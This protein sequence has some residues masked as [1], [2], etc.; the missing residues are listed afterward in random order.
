MSIIDLLLAALD[1]LL[2]GFAVGIVWE[3][4]RAREAAVPTQD[5]RACTC[6]PDETRPKECQ[7][8]YAL[9]ECRA[10][11]GLP[12]LFPSEEP[13]IVQRGPFKGK[14]QQ[15]FTRAE[16]IALLRGAKS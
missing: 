6:Y 10:A 5:T 4:R 2:V 15:W 1:G 12:D 16:V 9:N 7:H 8:K 13:L 11:A 3:R 14:P